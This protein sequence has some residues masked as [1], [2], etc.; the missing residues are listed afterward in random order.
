MTAEI[1]ALVVALLLVLTGLYVRGLAGRLDRLHLRVDA[2]SAALET[3]LVQRAGLSRELA[4]SGWLDP[5]SAVLL[6][7]A[8]QTA[9]AGVR[10]AEGMAR[11]AAQSDLSA[12]LRAVLVDP[13]TLVDLQA[14]PD[15]HDLLIELADASHGVVLARRFANDAVQAAVAVRRRWLVRS[16]HL[17]G[18]APWPISREM[19]DAPPESLAEIT[20]RAA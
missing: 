3:K 4:L 5:A 18:R 6:L 8:A 12:A 10:G 17:A 2:A 7:D 19:D 1:L 11:D 13:E 14:D 20:L 16:L 15:A 9:E